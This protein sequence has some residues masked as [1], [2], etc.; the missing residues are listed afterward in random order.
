MN[1]KS[2]SDLN[3][4]IKKNLSRI[5]NQGYDLVVG[6]PRSGIVPAYMIALYLNI[7]CTDLDSLIHNRPLK[8]GGSRKYKA[9][10]SLP[11]DAKKILV[12][13]DSIHKGFSLE[14][15]LT[16]IVDEI[17]GKITTLVIYSS[18]S[19]RKDVDFFFEYLPIPRVFEW[20]I[21]HHSVLLNSCVDID[22]VLCLDPSEEENDDGERYVSFILNAKPLFLPTYKI[23]SLVTSRLEKYRKETE[24]WLQK[25]NVTYS[26]LIML[27]LPSK[28]ERQR[29]N[30][31]ASHKSAYYKKSG[32]NF[33]IESN[34]AQ[35]VK[36]CELVGKPV[37]CV[38]NNQLYTPS[39][40]KE[41]SC[42]AKG[43]KRYIQLMPFKILK[44]ILNK[45][46]CK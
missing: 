46:D 35:S 44:G 38:N 11:H 33:F 17:K 12:V 42:K 24:Y 28:K 7:E 40:I 30:A 21:F 5:Q 34:V 36:I 43:F 25:H 10:L 14:R 41:L 6:L 23:H 45:M 18:L 8:K 1:Y 20:N 39:L 29:L 9:N 4:D 22:G 26:H 2:Y 15:D 3:Y 19:S 31:H 37:F 27:D 16:L 13:D 32:T